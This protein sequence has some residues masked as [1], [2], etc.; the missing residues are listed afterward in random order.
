MT[1]LSQSPRKTQTRLFAAAT[2][3]LA[4]ALSSSS[5]YAADA[6]ASA[7]KVV[8]RVAPS[9]PDLARRMHVTGIVHLDA[10]V[11]ADGHVEKAKATSGPPLLCGAAQDAVLRWKFT[12]GP[13][14]S[15]VSVQ[16]TFTD[17]ER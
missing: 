7:R 12:P 14:E 16:I 6:D 3:A 15:I 5:L 17:N 11:S 8:T 2:L 13:G 10:T 4:L 9:F 1:H